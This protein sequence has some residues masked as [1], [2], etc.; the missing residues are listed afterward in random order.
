[1]FGLYGLQ[2]HRAKG[3]VNQEKY[4]RPTG[5]RLNK[6]QR[7]K[8]LEQ[9][10]N[11]REKRRRSYETISEGDLRSVQ[12]RPDSRTPTTARR[13]STCISRASSALSDYLPL[14]RPRSPLV[15][16]SCRGSPS[17]VREPPGLQQQTAAHQ[18]G[19]GGE[20]GMVIASLESLARL[21]SCVAVNKAR[22][23]HRSCRTHAMH[24]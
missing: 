14:S 12:Q 20:N 6:R 19:G 18:K 9:Q 24:G 1:M 10:R 8:M 15:T 22:T 13:G 21:F 16:L 5:K 23:P 3:D 7:K 17:A 2:A 4:L 11:L